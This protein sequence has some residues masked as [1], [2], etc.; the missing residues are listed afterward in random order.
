LTR[1]NRSSRRKWLIAGV[2]CIFFVLLVSGI[3]VYAQIAE[4][5]SV[6]GVQ[7][8]E[9]YRSVK[10][11]NDTLFLVLG[12]I[13][14]TVPPTVYDA[15]QAF[16]VRL[17]DGAVELGTTS[18]YAYHN[19]GYDLGFCSIYFSADDVASLPVTWG[20]GYSI[21]IEGNP[22]L[23][24][25][26]TTATTAMDGTFVYDDDTTT[27]TD[28]TADANS[29]AANDMEFPPSAAAE[30]DDAYYFGSEG[31]FNILTVT[32][33]QNGDWAGSY[34]W[35]YWNGSSWV[36]PQG[37]TD[38]TTGFTAGVGT[39]DVSF[40][41]PMNWRSCAVD[42]VDLY[43]LRFRIATQ[44][45]FTT[46]PLGTQ[47]WTNTLADP[48]S[49]SSAVINWIDEGS[50][51]DAQDRLTAR[52]RSL[53]TMLEND[54]GGTTDLIE[55][56]AGVSKL[57]DEGEDYFV[58]SIDDLRAMCPDLF[59][60]VT[61]RPEFPE[62]GFVQDYY[63]GGDDADYD[64]YGVNWY[65]QTFTP[66]QDYSVSG[67]DL[68]MFRV[69]APGTVTVGLKADGGGLPTIGAPDLASGTIDG[70]D[71]TT[72]TGGEWYEVSFTTDYAVTSGTT[73]ALVVRAVGGGAT[74]YVGWR[75]DSEGTYDGGQACVSPDSGAVS[76]GNIP[77][78]DFMFS[79][80]ATDAYTLSYRN[81]L[82]NRLVGTRLDMTDLGQSL[83]G[84]SRMWMSA[85]IWVI[86]ACI[87][88]TVFFVRA[89]QSFKPA[90][91]VFAVML[92]F[93]ALAGFIYLEVAIVAA[94]LFAS[95]AI[96]SFFYKPSG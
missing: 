22:T 95:A 36:V 83:G 65:A 21:S 90:T 63:M 20:G 56:I 74:D 68:K 41:C 60:D 78:E 87:L 24:W 10:E 9:A 31:M 93:G 23:H 37:L 18:F 33:G 11:L 61:I 48:P 75:V 96:F 12:R 67:C 88:P 66:T 49:V 82:A 71:F 35:E 51:V 39:W 64:V 40:T 59:S 17:M 77:G 76:W 32:I 69:G 45:G 13:E 50:V 91:L 7:Q 8:I 6:F 62:T 58:A 80:R 92:P 38:G 5:D 27:Y 47:A 85:I 55:S 84:I 73:Y 28:D 54:W 94:F 4:P 25:L 19:D 46:Q 44:T 1:P 86:F 53:A 81:R 3:P 57:T 16:I 30:V 2:I 26:D 42:G 34:A 79:I 89:T 43:W 52:C 15:G 14:Y 29:A 72:H 70:D